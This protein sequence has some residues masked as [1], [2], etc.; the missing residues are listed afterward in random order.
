MV[1]D[2]MNTSEELAALRQRIG[3]VEHELEQLKR[4]VAM[5][6]REV[7]A[8]RSSVGTTVPQTGVPTPLAAGATVEAVTTSAAVPP[9]VS[10][11]PPLP[12]RMEAVPVAP[13]RILEPV[14]AVPP[15]FAREPEPSFLDTIRPWLERAQLWPPSGEANREVQL[16]AWWATRLGILFAVIGAVFFGVYVSVNTPP[17]VKFIE[18]L[19]A[20]LGVVALGVWLERKTPRFG[21]VVFAGGLALVFFATMAAYTVPGVKVL[22]N[23]FVA[24]LCQLAVTAAIGA[25]AWRKNSQPVATLAVVL[26]YVAAWFSFSGGFELFALVSAA[27]FA[28]LAVIWRRALDWEVPSVVAL[29]GFWG[30]YGTLV[31]GVEAIEQ[32]VL[33]AWVWAFVAGGYAV[34]F[35]RDDRAGRQKADVSARE[36]WVQNANSTAALALGWLTAW[37]AFP[38]RIG[39]FY[40]VAAVALGLAAWRRAQTVAGDVVS[41][42]LIA[43]ALGALTLAVIKWTDPE[44]TALALLVQAGVLLMTNRRLR[45]RVMAV[46]SVLVEVVSLT[47]WVDDT[48][49]RPVAAGSLSWVGRMVYLAGVM[50]W[51]LEMALSCGV[52]LA[53]ETRR[54]LVRVASG[55]GVGLALLA[56]GFTT[57]VA[58]QPS[59]LV[60]TAA[61][62]GAAGF[63]WKQRAPWIAA[64]VVGLAAHVALWS[65]LSFFGMP[66]VELWGNAWVVLAPTVVGAWWFGREANSAAIRV[67]W[68][69]SALALATLGA[70]VSV[71]YGASASLLGAL[72]IAGVLAVAA[73]WQPVRRWLWLSAWALGVG[74]I[75]HM[76]AVVHWQ[77]LL[78][79]EEVRWI[80]ALVPLIG[81]A[82]LA[83]WPRGRAQQVAESP[84]GGTQWATAIFAL[85]FAVAVAAARKDAAEAVWVLGGFALL[86]GVLLSWAWVGALRGIAWVFTVLATVVLAAR[87]DVLTMLTA[88][89]PLIAAVWLPAL[90]W[91]MSSRIRDGWTRAG[92]NADG[93]ICGQTWLAGAVTAVTISSLTEG[94]QRVGWLAGATVVAVVLTRV[95][96]LAVVEVATGLA[97]LAL[98]YGLSVVNAGGADAG[99][100]VGFLAVVAAALVAAGLPLV[101]PPG[102]IWDS[103]GARAFRDWL[104]PSAGLALVFALMLSQRGTLQPYVTVGWAVVALAWFGLG[105][106]GRLR[107]ARLLGLAGLA[108]C[109]PRMF[110]VDLS[111]T[112]YRIGAFCALGGVLLW[113]GFS[114][115]RF[116]HLIAGN[117]GAGKGG[118]PEGDGK[119]G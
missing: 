112:L 4:R 7:V 9:A 26:G 36:I 58:W 93:A 105:L 75:G 119:T 2:P 10:L 12:K 40:A 81:I 25:I 57:P 38:E 68:P 27:G 8:E 76:V 28:A 49:W 65:R 59:W 54:T 6:E 47:Y 44:M 20:S 42:V 97:L 18:L 23:R 13:A 106:F 73:P 77:G 16:G 109:V 51:A 32:V 89:G 118:A 88:G 66:P 108:V 74:A 78:W 52:E 17:W 19:G 14:T 104:Y 69:V 72:A 100:G 60:L 1:G 85:V 62:L 82:C 101:L 55:V 80:A 116:R 91:A 107:P 92:A 102:R 99:A 3:G 39:I 56:A 61:V 15:V 86:A 48:L 83:A 31:F 113:V 103:A 70:C 53:Q 11:P 29:V 87:S 22:E 94:G 37:M 71:G 35:W 63:F 33:P 98:I 50:A 114:Y 30:I 111:S 90:G 95:T 110:L 67:A 84:R 34:F 96:F 24:A 117:E 79:V 41:A 46:G 21:Q 5:I 45:S 115:H 64:G 43:K